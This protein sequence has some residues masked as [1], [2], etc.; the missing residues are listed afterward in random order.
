MPYLIK[1]YYEET[2]FEALLQ[3]TSTPTII[4]LSG[5]PSNNNYDDIMYFYYNKGFNVFYPRYS[6]FYQSGGTFLEEGMITKLIDFV[7]YIKKGSIINLWD[8]SKVSFK[9]ED[10][11]ICSGSLGGSVA[12]AIAKNIKIDKMI[13]FSPVFDF[14]QHNVHGDEQDLNAIG[15]FTRKA[16]KNCIR[17]KSGDLST[18][19]SSN[20]ELKNDLEL[21]QTKVLIF[22]DPLD[23]TVNIR[24]SIHFSE[25]NDCE[26]E[27]SYKGHGM[28]WKGVKENELK[29]LDFI[30]S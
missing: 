22:H 4:L 3:E 24:N 21:D 27:K 13:L 5:F 20:S 28:K 8:N 7:N 23:E 9:A 29:I 19:L 12:I 25:F 16:Y 17:L 15:E 6:G 30:Q 14:L 10:I 18:Q 26:L 1:S 2:F 11:I